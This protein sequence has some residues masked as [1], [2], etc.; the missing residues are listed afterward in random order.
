VV[1][2]GDCQPV[3][4]SLCSDPLEVFAMGAHFS[5]CLSPGGS[6]FFSVITNAA[7]VNKRVLY[8]RRG[9]KVVGRCLLALTDGGQ[10]LTFHPYAHDNRLGF[11]ALVARFAVDL[12]ARMRTEVTTTGRVTT[13]L[14]RDWY[15]DGVRDLVGRY[16]SL[17]QPAFAEALQRVALSGAVALLVKTLGRGLDDLTLP[18]VVATPALERR[19][20]LIVVLAPLL[21]ARPTLPDDTLARA[22]GLA[23]RAG[24]AELADRLLMGP[25]SRAD[26]KFSAWYWGQVL[27]RR[28]PSF[29]LAR[30]RETRPRG[31]RGWDDEVGGRLAVAALAMETLHRP[32]QAVAFYRRA[33]AD[34]PELQNE[35]GDRLAALERSLA[36]P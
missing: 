26:L 3:E 32:R 28:Q 18:V 22:A 8:A 19:P 35:V 30:L 5:T 25:A 36:A 20:E 6:N 24:E 23:T 4:L 14:A 11:D 12:A 16:G 15:D 2:A 7:D 33:I 17:A 27:A 9:G 34:D 29:A 21:L 1:I 13:L 10:L 31:V